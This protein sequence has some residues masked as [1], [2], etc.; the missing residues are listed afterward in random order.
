MKCIN[1]IKH[2]F[3]MYHPVSWFSKF[4]WHD[5]DMTNILSN[6]FIYTKS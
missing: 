1:V 4:V 3:Y 5:Y 2:I 6:K